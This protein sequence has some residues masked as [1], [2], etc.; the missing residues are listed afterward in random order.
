MIPIW[1]SRPRPPPTD[2]VPYWFSSQANWQNANLWSP[3][4]STLHGRE[5]LRFCFEREIRR[6]QSNGFLPSEATRLH[7]SLSVWPNGPG[8]FYGTYHAAKGLEFDTVFMPL[9]SDERWPHPPDVEM[10]GREESASRDSRL[11]YVGIT[12][13]RSTLVLTYTRQPT[14]LLPSTAGL[15]QS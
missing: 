6:R 12:R 8:L 4:R 3:G 7:R 10:L 11:L 2:R 14:A 15:Y 9:L 13:A 5:P 1:W